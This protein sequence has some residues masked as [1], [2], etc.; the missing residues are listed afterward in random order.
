MVCGPYANAAEK[1]TFVDLVNQMTDLERLAVLP[2]PGQKC[3]QWSSYHRAS[4][5]DPKS[6]TYIGWDTNKDGDGFI[7]EENGNLVLA[8]M[9][10]P[11][12]IW[13]IWSAYTEDGHVKIYLDGSDQPVIDMPFSHY[14]DG[15]HR[16]FNYPELSYRVVGRTTG[17]KPDFNNGR[18]LYFPIPYQKSCKIIAEAGWGKYYHF[19]YSTFPRGTKVPTFKTA[20]G[21]DEVT[22]LQ[23]LNDKLK[24]KLGLDPA[25][26]RKGEVT[27]RKT[28]TVAPGKTVTIAELK[29]RRAITALKVRM[30][31]PQS[32]Q[33]RYPLRELALSFYWDGESEASVW[34]PLGDF[35]GTAIGANKYKSLPLGVTDDEF[36]SYWYMPFA[37][38]AL[39]QLTNDGDKEYEV[40][41]IITHAPVKRPIKKLGRFHAK[42]HRD[43]FIPQRADRRPDWTMLKTAGRGRFCGVM[44]HV[45]NPK[46][47]WWGEGDEKFFVDGEKF[48]STFG[49]GSEDYFGYAW[50]DPTLFQRPYHNQTISMNNT[51]HISVNRFQIADNVPFQKSFEGAIEKYFPNDRPTLYSAIAYWYLEPGGLD[52]YPRSPVSQR[53]SHLLPQPEFSSAHNVFV[54]STNVII[55]GS[56]K[57]IQ[58]YYTLDGT[59]P[60]GDSTKYTEPIVLTASAT[61]KARAFKAGYIPSMI[62]T[63]IQTKTTYHQPDSPADI[64]NGLSYNYYKG[65]WNKVPNFKALQPLRV[66]KIDKFRFPQGIDK[67]YF[68]LEFNGFIEVRRDGIYTFYLAS[69][70]GSKLY[71]GDRLVVD[72][73]GRHS[74]SAEKSGGVALRAGKHSIGVVYF[75]GPRGKGLKAFY[76]GP[77]IEKREIGPEVL[78]H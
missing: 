45:W 49:T 69:D 60:T 46:G 70:D 53:I 76:S 78:F 68:G 47:V 58:I 19:T 54:G 44:L 74:S 27:E 31:L 71:I 14:F 24:N 50:C 51:G 10:G 66:G 57:E 43:A 16:P 52:P 21:P 37:K 26:K 33:D 48:P 28:V 55:E 7:R 35:F 40:T 73:D 65:R 2:Q 77:G 67:F 4:K 72:H 41:F 20:L 6:D 62:S 17:Y 8:E 36:Y 38:G 42:W 32:P 61:I 18:N 39:L 23:K 22:A 25:G 30:D 1:L 64:G 9:T 3:G 63:D 59:E 12:V 5:Y 75:Q 56:T 13:R 11:G 15:K 34:A 29:G